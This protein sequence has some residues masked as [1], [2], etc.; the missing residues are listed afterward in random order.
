M[1]NFLAFVG[2]AIIALVGLGWYLDWFNITPQKSDQGKTSINVEF[3]QDKAGKDVQEGLKKGAEKVQDL[4][5]KNKP[6]ETTTPTSNSDSWYLPK[7][8]SN[9][10][11]TKRSEETFK[12]V[13]TD[14]WF[15][16]DRK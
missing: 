16:G 6:A 13:V 11:P 12:N 3:N 14:G 8:N 7:A 2:A 15:S 9:T 10:R 1:K 5:D 4:L